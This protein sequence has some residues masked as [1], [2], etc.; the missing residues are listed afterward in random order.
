MNVQVLQRSVMYVTYISSPSKPFF[1]KLID[2]TLYLIY[3]K[4]FWHR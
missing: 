3:N 2:F 4:G 1:S